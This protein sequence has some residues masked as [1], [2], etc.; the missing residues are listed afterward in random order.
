MVL[1]IWSETSIDLSWVPA[2]DDRGRD[3]VE[4]TIASGTLAQGAKTT[5][6]GYQLKQVATAIKETKQ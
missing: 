1:L 3:D 6:L 4:E 2:V 5:R